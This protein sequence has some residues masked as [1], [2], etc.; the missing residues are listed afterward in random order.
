MFK[1][2]KMVVFSSI[3]YIHIFGRSIDRAAMACL[4][5]S[6]LSQRARTITKRSKTKRTESQ[7]TGKARVRRNIYDWSKRLGWR[8]NIGT[9]NNWTYFGKL[10]KYFCSFFF[11]CSILVFLVFLIWYELFSQ[12]ET[13]S[14]VINIVCA[15]LLKKNK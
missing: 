9:N 5:I 1:N 15:Q 8:I 3:K 14:I 7:S 6:L 13:Q 2:K 12:C 11:V 10:K 4:R